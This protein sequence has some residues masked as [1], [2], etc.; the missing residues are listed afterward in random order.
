MFSLVR[1]IQ[2]VNMLIV[3]MFVCSAVLTNSIEAVVLLLATGA[4]GAIFSSTAPDMGAEG[5]ISR[6]TQIRPKI[7]FVETE[8]L[9]AG[10]R[11]TLGNKIATAVDKLRERVPELSKVVVVN[12]APLRDGLR[13][14]VFI[15]LIN[16]S[17]TDASD[18]LLS[19][20]LDKFLQVLVRSLHFNQLPFDHSI[21]ILYSSGTTGTPKCRKL[22]HKALRY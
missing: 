21:Y 13:Y 11:R 12:G 22:G 15:C 20:P 9:Y 16:L 1:H 17:A 2:T 6:Y 18:C 4:I 19:I 14:V 10:K 7:L 8:V 5:I 3:F